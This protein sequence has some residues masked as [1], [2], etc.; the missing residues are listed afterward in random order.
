MAFLRE[1][2]G[3]ERFIVLGL[4]SGA[5]T[6]FHAGMARE[7]PIERLVLI[8]PW[9][10]YWSEGMSLDTSVNHYEKVAAYQR[11]MRDPERWKKLLTGQVQLGRLA[12]VAG[13][14][15]MKVVRGQWHDLK[16]IVRPGS[17][18][19]LSHDVRA[20]ATLGRRTLIYV[21][22]GEPAG[23]VLATEAK[24]SVKRATR[25]GLLT[26]ERIPGGDHTFSQLAPR[27]VLVGRIRAALK[28]NP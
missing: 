26:V 17:G 4:C 6:A 21:S 15:L 8:N 3:H 14:H 2:F 12:K 10:F 27:D 1:R 18:T 7:R 11:S 13:A 23:A 22:D 28:D 16:D 5:H 9:H 24:R 19:R 20:L 25:A